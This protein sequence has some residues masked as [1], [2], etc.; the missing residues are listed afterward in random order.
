MSPWVGSTQGACGV[1]QG[2]QASPFSHPEFQRAQPQAMLQTHHTIT[3]AS[4]WTPSSVLHPL[5]WPLSQP[6]GF[7]SEALLSELA[8]LALWGSGTQEAGTASANPT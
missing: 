1:Q 7:R 6:S 2:R 5:C 4:A 8:S 3:L